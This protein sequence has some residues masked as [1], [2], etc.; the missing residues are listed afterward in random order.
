MKAKKGNIKKL[1][2]SGNPSVPGKTE[3][4]DRL[5]NYVAL[6]AI[7][8]ISFIAYSPVLHNSFLGWDDHYY[9][10]DNPLVSNFNLIKIFSTF[11]M[12]N[13][14]PIT[15]LTLATEYHLFGLNETG[16]HAVNLVLHLA[17][18]I[19]VFY[20]ILLMCNKPGVA[21]IASLLFGI[22][23]IHVESVA[24]AAEL[25]DL[26]Y[27]FF[28]LAAMI[29]YLKY[30]S[31][32]RS[33]FYYF[34]LMLF[35]FSILSKAM[36][37]SFPVVL[38]LIDYFKDR[39][40][41]TKVILEKVPFFML[42]FIFGVVAI[43]A[44]KT[45]S[46]AHDITIFSFP[47]RIV[48]AG[49]AFITYLYKLILPIHLSAYYPYPIKNGGTIPLQYYAYILLLIGV[50]SYAFYSQKS[51]KKMLLG[52]GFFSITVFLVLQLM[53]VGGAIMADRY[54]YV[55]SIGISYLGAEGINYLW[56]KSLKWLAISIVS[57]LTVFYSLAT[58]SR[59]QIWKNDLSL[60]NDVISNYQTVSIAYYNRGLSYMNENKTNLAFADYN[61]TIELMPTYTEAY[62]NR[63]SIKRDSSKYEEALIDYN[64][65]IEISPSY[66]TAYFN[67]GILYIKENKN[68]EAISDFTKTIELD[69]GNNKAY[70][71]R[72]A[73]YFNEKR[74][75]EAIADYSRAIALKPDAPEAYYNRA[76]AQFYA[77]HQ[78]LVAEDLKVASKL[79][80]Q[81][82]IDALQRL[83]K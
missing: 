63:G 57:V 49:Y 48:F 2:G 23:P 34:A 74:Y 47:Q 30:I 65:A 3:H 68:E 37:A 31:T 8:T 10:S 83:T 78:D 21:L 15:I 43:M 67:R 51:T 16:Y 73:V 53:P 12:G 6:A 11:V 46:L 52:I 18:I 82:A 38:F 40:I 22:H 45:T 76:M 24:W 41:N 77:G 32:S 26:L 70:S 36:A 33:K 69:P 44:Q 1:K 66:A 80:Y 59:C 13:Y 35:L 54:A 9:I 7:L 64:K 62:V 55:P 79:G 29:C 19:L 81:P 28:F 75:P 39:K 50:A 20:S 17:N 4:S 5:K 25:K 71:N 56:T 61:K 58:Y 42:A 14:H 72:G 60:W 27:T